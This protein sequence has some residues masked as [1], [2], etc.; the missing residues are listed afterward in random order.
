MGSWALA[1]IM[2]AGVMAAGVMGCGQAP[3]APTAVPEA[4]RVGAGSKGQTETDVLT[5]RPSPDAVMPT[6]P[7]SEADPG[8]DADVG[9]PADAPADEPDAEPAPAS[10]PAGQVFSACHE[11]RVVGC[12]AVYVR[13][14]KSTPDVCV[15]LVLDNCGEN[16]RKT[17]QVAVPISWRLTSGS[18]ST[19]QGCDLREYDPKS[20]PVLSASGKVNFAQ[21]GRQISALDIDVQLLLDS[22][23]ESKVPGQIAVSTPSPIADIDTCEQ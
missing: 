3:P 20:E 23:S 1:D 2:A 5:V 7:S 22:T 8:T 19:G 15:Q 11:T 14:V 16:G 4:Q 10:S 18:A 6:P 9:D 13:I 21:Q 17:L 12:D